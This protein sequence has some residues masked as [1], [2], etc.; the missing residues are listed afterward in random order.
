MNPVYR[1]VHT[2]TRC[3][4]RLYGRWKI[5]GHEKIPKTG[6]VIV[7]CNH[8]SYLDPT[9]VGSAIKRECRFMARHDLWD[10]KKLAWLLPRL[11]T[12]P[13]HRDQVDKQ[14][15]KNGL[16]ALKQGYVFVIF[17][18]GG[19]SDDGNLQRGELGVALFVQKSGAPVVPCA[20]IGPEKMLPVGASKLTRVPLK[21]VF[22]DPIHFAPKTG[23][24]EIMRRVMHEIAALLTANGIPSTAK[25][26]MDVTAESTRNSE[27][28]RRAEEVC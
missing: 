22:G 28:P 7:A 17:P 6:P 11:G 19:R 13:V 18:E 25:E 10:N 5:I 15:I 4:H 8:V 3:F 24:E 23:R 9:I 20:V 14:A 12:F 27:E 21:C 1:T 16:D 26:D 2:L